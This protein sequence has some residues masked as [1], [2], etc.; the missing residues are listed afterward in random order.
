MMFHASGAQDETALEAH[1]SVL[2]IALHEVPIAKE[3][4]GGLVAG[5][6]D[7]GHGW[8]KPQVPC[9]ALWAFNLVRQTM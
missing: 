8:P 9:F 7:V 1:V 2:S 4:A 5:L 6:L 3:A